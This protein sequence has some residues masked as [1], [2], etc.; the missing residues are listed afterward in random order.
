MYF[1]ETDQ[2]SDDG[3]QPL[4]GSANPDLARQQQRRRRGEARRLQLTQAVYPTF[5]TSRASFCRDSF[6]LREAA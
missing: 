6:E 2:H 3:L 4:P 1:Q 5:R